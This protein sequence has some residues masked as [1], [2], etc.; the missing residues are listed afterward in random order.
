MGEMKHTRFFHAIVCAVFAISLAACGN[1]SSK[2]PNAD[3]VERATASDSMGAGM[4]EE[5]GV[6]ESLCGIC[7]PELAA[8]LEPGQGTADSLSV[9]AIRCSGR[10]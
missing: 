6:E 10:H 3:H 9:V 8:A 4:C 7:H 2:A 1:T 5:H